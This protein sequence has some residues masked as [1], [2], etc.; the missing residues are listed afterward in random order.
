VV[1]GPAV[2]EVRGPPQA[3]VVGAVQGG[4]E[5]PV[6]VEDV[7][8]RQGFQPA[9]DE[10]QLQH[11]VPACLLAGHVDERPEAE[12][13]HVASPPTPPRWGW[14]APRARVKPP[15]MEARIVDFAEILRQNGVR[16]SIAEV[17]DAV[18]ATAE[19]GVADRS[20]FK[21]TLQAT[22]V[23]READLGTFE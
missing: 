20:L 15:A 9:G 6:E 1:R 22:L 11:G 2:D 8:R 19:V 12:L 16:V 13:G 7:P 17:Q 23:K 21:A 18:G 5:V 4:G 10:V 14:A 3:P